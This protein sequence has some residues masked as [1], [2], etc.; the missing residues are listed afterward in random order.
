MTLRLGLALEEYK[1][2]YNELNH[3]QTHIHCCLLLIVDM[4]W[5]AMESLLP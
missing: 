1:S 4:M 2:E 3:K 5:R